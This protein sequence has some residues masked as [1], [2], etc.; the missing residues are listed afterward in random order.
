MTDPCE[1]VIK[2]KPRS[3]RARLHLRRSPPLAVG[4][5][6]QLVFRS[7][8][9]W[10]SSST[11]NCGKVNSASGRTKKKSR[12]GATCARARSSESTKSL[13]VDLD[14]D[15]DRQQTSRVRNIWRYDAIARDRNS[16]LEIMKKSRRSRGIRKKSTDHVAG[17]RMWNTKLTRASVFHSLTAWRGNSAPLRFIQASWKLA[18]SK[19]RRVSFA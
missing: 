4:L 15:E 16:F 13:D 17:S 8:L 10:Y 2:G 7:Y 12:D 11:S 1:S 6:K 5:L 9:C 14:H 3:H 18:K 19:E